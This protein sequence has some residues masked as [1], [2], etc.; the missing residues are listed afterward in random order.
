VAL[1]GKPTWSSTKTATKQ[2]KPAAGGRSP[3]QWVRR[4]SGVT[5]F[6]ARLP[7]KSFWMNWSMTKR[8]P[9]LGWAVKAEGVF[10]VGGTG[11]AV[12]VPACGG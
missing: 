3:Q 7:R 10:T 4:Y 5:D 8:E 9:G 12:R 2:F 11:F 1:D 6:R